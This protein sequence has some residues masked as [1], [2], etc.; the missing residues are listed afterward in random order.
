[1][2]TKNAM[3]FIDQFSSHGRAIGP[4]WVC[5][6]VTNYFSAAIFLNDVTLFHEFEAD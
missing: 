1:L 4:V 6:C 3:I 2:F 5:I